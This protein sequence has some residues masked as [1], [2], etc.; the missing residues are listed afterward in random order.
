MQGLVI[1]LFSRRNAIGIGLDLAARAS[2]AADGRIDRLDMELAQVFP[3][4]EGQGL[5]DIHI[6]VEEEVTVRRMII[7]GVE[8][9]KGF[10]CQAGDI[11][12]IAARF[13]A[14]RR[15]REEGIHDVPFHL[16]IRRRKD[17]FH[18][19]INDTAISQL[20]IGRIEMIVPAF[21]HE[22]LFIFDHVREKDGIQIDIHEVLEIGSVAAGYGI[23]GLVR[24]R[25]GIEE[26]VE[27]TLYQFDEGF[28]EGELPGA[29]KGRMFAD[30]GYA[31]AVR[32]RRPE[33]NGKDF[34][35]VIILDI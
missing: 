22:D 1:R 5:V 23:H 33:R 31:R 16:R 34:I 8:G 11:I 35:V 18:F 26:G 25:H 10:L 21:L 20:T 32:R 9:S 24:E 6:A 28:L 12:G 30:M 27:R 17:A 14:I 19:V 15:I 29:A 4:D 13:D 2:L 7:F 3:I